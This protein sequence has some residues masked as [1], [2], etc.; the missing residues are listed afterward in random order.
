MQR[1]TMR[2]HAH[3]FLLLIF[4]QI[5]LRPQ[6]LAVYFPRNLYRTRHV[7]MSSIEHY[8]T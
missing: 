5:Q 8:L 4:S 7:R 2:I 6:Y 3:V 1:S